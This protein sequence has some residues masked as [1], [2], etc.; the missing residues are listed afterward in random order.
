MNI[1]VPPNLSPG[2]VA[3]LVAAGLNDWGG[4][5]PVTPD[6]VNPEAPWPALDR[7]A[8]ATEQ[9]GKVLVERLAIYPRY[10]L[11]GERWLC[12]AL[13]TPVLHAIDSEGY[14]RPDPWCPGGS[15]PPPAG[16][17]SRAELRDGARLGRILARALDGDG[18]DEA[19]IVRL[20]AARGSEVAEVCDAADELRAAVNGDTVGYVVNRNINY[21]NVCQYRCGFCAFSKGK[22]NEDLRGR[23]YRLDLDE[24]MRRTQEAWSRGATEVCMQGGIHPS[25][26]GH[27]YL[28]IC[29]AVKRAVPEIHVHAFSPL[30]VWHGAETLGLSVSEFLAQLGD[31]GLGSLPGTAAEILDDQVRAVIC[32]DKLTTQQ[33]LSVMEAAHAV[34]LRSTATIMFGHVDA[35]RH[36]ARHLLRIRALQTRTGGFTEFVPLPFVHMEA[37]IFLKGGARK[38]PTFRECLLMQAVA[39]LALHPHVSNIQ[40]SWPKLGPKG[41]IAGLRAGANDLGGTLMNESISRAAGAAHGQEI[42]PEQME[43]LA[44]RAGRVAR[45]RTTLFGRPGNARR[46]AAYD[47]PELGP[48]VQIPPG[49]GYDG[50]P[51]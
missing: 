33:W 29:R 36:W 47:A 15:E 3:R 14:A 42:A 11:D 38:G 41:A 27:T 32:P 7:L 44:R 30:E 35:P 37:P 16:L 4:V 6:F 2:N 48:V 50:T 20:F 22:L 9:A 8:D 23:P 49:R 12:K 28:E 45:Q 5:S 40:V 13:R 25:Y 1:Q 46:R 31:T 39:R 51:R 10:A 24:I 43:A 26:T 17:G 34:G 21:T 18:L 19:D